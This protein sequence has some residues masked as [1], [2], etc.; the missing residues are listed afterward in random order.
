MCCGFEAGTHKVIILPYKNITVHFSRST[1]SAQRVRR[2]A[3]KRLFHVDVVGQISGLQSLERGEQVRSV[4][5]NRRK[6]AALITATAAVTSLLAGAQLVQADVTWNGSGGDALWS[7]ANNWTGTG[8]APTST[9]NVTFDDSGEAHLANTVDAAATTTIKRLSY[10]QDNSSFD[11]TTNAYV[12]SID[13]GMTLSP[14][15]A[16]TSNPPTAA[17]A[18]LLVMPATAATASTA[19]GTYVKINSSG[20][21][22]GALGKLSM[23]SASGAL[24]M[25][26]SGKPSVSATNNESWAVLDL[27]GLSSFTFSTAPSFTF[28]SIGIGTGNSN[29]SSDQGAVS[30]KLIL[31]DNTTINVNRFNIGGQ[32]NVATLGNQ[33]SSLLVLGQTNNINTVLS[34]NFT[35]GADQD[36]TKDSSGVV[37]FRAGLA[38]PVVNIG[39]NAGNRNGFGMARNNGTG[40][41]TYGVIDLTSASAGS[42]GSITGYFSRARIGEGSTGTSASG[43]GAGMLSFDNGTIDVQ[44]SASSPTLALVLG[45][46]NNAGNVTPIVGQVNVGLKG[47]AGDAGAGIL[48]TSQVT[49]GT[50]S[51][52]IIGS[53]THNTNTSS[54]TAILNTA[55]SGI[56]AADRIIIGDS[57]QTN[58]GTH[59]GSVTGILNI[60]GTVKTGQVHAGGDNPQ[61]GT[62]TTRLVNFHGGTLQM[63]AINDAV[64]N[65]T[66][67]YAGNYMEGLN[68]AYVYSEGGTIDTNGQNVT[69]NQAL[70][71]PTGQGVTAATITNGGS[72]YRSAPIVVVARGA[73]DTTGTGATAVARINAAGTVTGITITNP[74][75]DYTVAP[76]FQLIAN[77]GSNYANQQVPFGTASTVV[78]AQTATIAGVIS[79][80]VGGGIT[81]TG[82]GTLTINGANT[83]T[84]PTNVNQ[85]ELKLGTN[86]TTSSNVAVS[87]TGTVTIPSNG[88]NNRVIKTGSVSVTGSGNINIDDNKLILTAQ[89]VG[90]W[91]GS[92]YTDVTGL[93]AAG[94]TPNNDFSGNGIVTTQSNATGGNTLTNIGVVSNSDIGA[95]TFGGQS[96]GANDTLV[97]YTYGGDANLDG[98]V[99]GD[100]YFQID[101]ATASSHGWFNGDFNYD[102]IINGDDYF[103]I[104]SNFAAQGAAISMTS[105]GLAG[106]TAVPEPASIALV[107][108]AA[109]ALLGRRRR[110]RAAAAN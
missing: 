56:V 50:A 52:I 21:G 29:T 16:A 105:S 104:D 101:S 19:T 64:A 36:G 57:T 10:T 25:L 79:N 24:S 9:D 98:V 89:G 72:G 28:S 18:S 61:L 8:L 85:G 6:T 109:A 11:G 26:I 37:I 77:A 65:P 95:S 103:L 2:A 90:T 107:G 102:G 48:Q 69:I 32:S 110:N 31:S 5:S 70:L 82:V 45:A 1:N 68:G 4:R 55:N 86:L 38:G 83:Y 41:Q 13:N 15:I 30:G 46:T 12:T 39:D 75:T 59:T 94:Y 7:N 27:S 106:V 78:T 54:S 60:G 63:K 87:G 35:V 17:N 47:G 71:A 92:A 22:T 58:D 80:N 97:A 3:G 76:V 66:Y 20:V 99:N 62:N 100:D 91:N 108:V 43:G 88:A 93:I 73:G 44:G 40:H 74:G 81:K 51:Q 33:A 23:V 34:G 84:G 49:A 67:P 14:Y 42:D 53:R 96:V